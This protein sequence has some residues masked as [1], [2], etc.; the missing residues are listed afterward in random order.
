GMVVVGAGGWWAVHPGSP[1]VHAAVARRVSRAVAHTVALGA[2][3]TPV[4]VT[5]CGGT[6]TGSTPP[7]ASVQSSPDPV[8]QVTSVSG[9]TVSWP[10]PGVVTVLYF[11]SA[12]CGSCIAGE[13]Q[14]AA[15]QA[16]LPATVRLLSLDVTP[17]VDTAAM[18][19]AVAR[20]TGAHWP[21]AF[22][23]PALLTAYHVVALD[24]VAILTAQGRVV[25]DGGLP[26]N[27]QMRQEIA[28][29]EA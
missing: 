1:P 29:A 9:Q 20:E 14:L 5:C 25:Y 11:M 18:L 22:A 16:G 15:L 8:D 10:R 28:Q 13:R 3:A 17:E 2:P 12:Q 27:G 23:T 7:A 4:P 6:V 21:Q 24:Q 19:R 26:S